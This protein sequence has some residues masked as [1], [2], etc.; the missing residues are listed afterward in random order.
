MNNMAVFEYDLDKFIDSAKDKDY[1]N[2]E[3]V[4]FD[5]FAKRLHAIKNESEDCEVIK[6]DF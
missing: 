4:K 3:I 5:D 2:Q 6:C 1:G